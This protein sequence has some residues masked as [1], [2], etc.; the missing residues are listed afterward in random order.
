M[1][2]FLVLLCLLTPCLAVMAQAELTLDPARQKTL[3]VFFSNFSEAN[4]KSF[5]PQTLSDATLLEF[6]LAHNLINRRASLQTSKD[7]NSVMI[8]STQ[9]DA[10]TEKY[11]GKKV[12]RHRSATYT[13]ALADG[14]AY[15]FSQ[16]RSLTDLG[17]QTYLANGV[18]YRA[19]SGGT[20]NPH[21]TPAQWKKA[22]DEV[23]QVGSF[24]ARIKAMDG[25][26][27]LLEYQIMLK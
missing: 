8:P 12:A 24:I 22:G 9:V 18:I 27:V 21:G 10:T 19:D 6:A 23:E 7:G 25:R 20:P 5:T 13:Q 11:F 3:N 1:K 2:K 14:E 4:L 16:I 26:Y 15:T 17:G